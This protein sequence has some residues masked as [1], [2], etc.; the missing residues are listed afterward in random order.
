MEQVEKNTRLDLLVNYNSQQSGNTNFL[1]PI[2]SSSD[3][4][5]LAFLM[6]NDMIIE[7]HLYLENEIEKKSEIEFPQTH[8]ITTCNSI[9]TNAQNQSYL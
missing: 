2:Q 5:S 1:S 3:P 9:S 8:V 7:Y 6:Q 4:S